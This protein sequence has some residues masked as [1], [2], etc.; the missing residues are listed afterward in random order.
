MFQSVV[1]GVAYGGYVGCNSKMQ[2]FGEVVRRLRKQKRLSQDELGAA[3]GLNGQT[4]SNLETGKIAVPR[5][6]TYRRL[7]EGLGLTVDALDAEARGDAVT[8]TLPRATYNAVK[9]KAD[10]KGETVEAWI[11]RA[12]EDPVVII[13]KSIPPDGAAPSAP[14]SDPPSGTPRAPRKRR[15]QLAP[16]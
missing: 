9:A 8:V 16:K 1:N 5:G 12:V 6:D 4:V 7:A 15:K 2:K 3:A 13:K 11:A 10:A 14:A